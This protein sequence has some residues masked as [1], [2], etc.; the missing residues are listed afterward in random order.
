MDAEQCTN[1]YAASV[2][3]QT[4]SKSKVLFGTPGLDPLLEVDSTSCR[5]LFSEDG[6]TWAAIGAFLYEL[7]LTTNTATSIGTIANDGKPVSFASNGRGGEQL[8][9]CSGGELYV[10]ELDTGTFTGPIAL[11]LTNPARSVSFLDGY[12]LILEADTVKGYFSALED[13]TDVDALDFFARSQ[14]SDNFVAMAVLRD[15]IWMI[16]SATTDV[17]FDSGDADT[18]FVPYPSAVFPYGIVGPDALTSDGESLYWLAQYDQGRAGF[19]RATEGGVQ[20]ISTDAI[21]FVVAQATSLDDTEALSYWQ[22]GHFHACWTLPSAGTC[23]ATYC[24]DSKEQ[25]WH[26]RSYFDQTL[27][28]DMRW[29]VRG[30]ASTSHGLIC[31]DFETSNIYILSLDCQTDNGSMIK[32]VRRAPYLSADATIGF[33]DQFELGAEVGLGLNQGQGSDPQAMLRISR[34]AGKTWGPT[35]MAPLGK[36]GNYLTRTVWHRLGRVRLDRLVIEASVTDAVPIRWGP[37]AWLRITPSNG[38]L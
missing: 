31:G 17:W 36:Q 34:D 15:R 28:I 2:E 27:G 26:T 6:R 22:E 19:V 8:A 11:P 20:P 10:L 3:S 12:G 32:R 7:N 38:Q 14:T 13:F 30:I 37:G 16:G 33:V 25:L 18:P 29:R 4:N 9:I 1:L 35:L 24:F 5:G 21:D 23:G